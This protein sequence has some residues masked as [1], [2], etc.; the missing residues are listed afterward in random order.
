VVVTINPAGVPPNGTAYQGTVVI[1]V[2]GATNSPI[3]LP[4]SLTVTPQTVAPNVVAIQN[5][6]SFLPTSSSPGL[7]ILIYGTNMGPA[8]I[9]QLQV[10]ANGL[11]NTN[12]AGTRV[13][14]DGVQA[15]IVFTR[16]DLV[17]VIVPYE[18]AGRATSSMI[19]TYNG[20][21]STPLQLRV[22]DSSPAIFTLTQ[23]GTGQGAILNQ[24]GTVNSAGNPELVGNI[25]Q[26]F[27]TGEGLTAPTHVTGTVYPPRLGLPAPILPVG[28][29]IGGVPVP[30]SD[31]TY[32]A[33]APGGV[34]GLIQINAKIP[35][36]VGT[37]PQQVFF[38]V[39]GAPSQAGVTVQVR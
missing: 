14:F 39:G 29:T 10:G 36:G 26:I 38:T 30:P 34:A 6:G 3:T 24:N 32:A 21:S 20:V 22:V 19:V 5:N 18:I 2:P 16:T 33:E 17:S 23:T 12:L 11:V 7:I 28:V 25:I 9:T 4:I 37:G 15:P 31:I 8:T 27:G 1:S 35:A 13:T